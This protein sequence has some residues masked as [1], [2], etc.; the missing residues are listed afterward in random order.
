MSDE[1]KQCDKQLSDL[2]KLFKSDFAANFPALLPP[3]QTLISELMQIRIRLLESHT[4][5]QENK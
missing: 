3:L 2:S 4:Q 1:L 5:A